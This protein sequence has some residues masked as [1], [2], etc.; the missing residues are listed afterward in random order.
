MWKGVGAVAELEIRHENEHRPDPAGQKIG[1]LAAILA[2]FLALVTIASHRTHTDGIVLKTE[3]NDQWQYYQSER[4]K[5][6]NLELGEDLI[7]LLG[8][9]NDAVEKAL[10][11]YQAE[12][13]RYKREGEKIQG[14]A[15]E[16]EQ[17]ARH[18]ERQALRFDFGEGL[19]EIGLVL[20]SLYF[21]SRKKFFPLLGLMAGIVG[22]VI[23]ATGLLVS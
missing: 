7:M 11:K 12:K 18:A 16:K 15:K 6:H 4:I 19:L 8:A 14:E 2:V 9:K 17:E 20:T 13:A 22:I 5:Y 10:Q 1:I 21:I 23:A 3:A